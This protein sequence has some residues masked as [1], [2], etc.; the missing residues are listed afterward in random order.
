MA[1]Q[2][3]EI[4]TACIENRRHVCGKILKI[5]PEGVVVDSG[6]T[7]LTSYPL[8]RSW[9]VPQTAAA[10]RAVNLLEENQPNAFCVGLVFLDRTFPKTPAA[11]PKV[12]DFINL[13]GL[14]RRTIYLRVSGG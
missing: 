1:L 11:K 8:N 14:S 2:R 5:L 13:G 10:T 6:Y 7:N 12:Y 4:R 9:L 3:E